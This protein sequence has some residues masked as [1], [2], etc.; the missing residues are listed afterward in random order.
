MQ[1]VSQT[2]H[3]QTA[4]STNKKLVSYLEKPVSWWE[5]SMYKF[6]EEENDDVTAFTNINQPETISSNKNQRTVSS[7]S[8]IGLTRRKINVEVSQSEKSRYNKFHV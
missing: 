6:Y 3:Q 2:K 5:I 7:M 1:H 8:K 4:S